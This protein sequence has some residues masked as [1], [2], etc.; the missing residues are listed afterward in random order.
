M[1]ILR[2]RQRSVGLAQHE[3]W[4]LFSASA[5]ILKSILETDT[6]VDLICGPARAG[7]KQVFEI[8][9]EE[10]S[11]ALLHDH[12]TRV[13]QTPDA[14]RALTLA[15]QTARCGK[16]AI[17]LIPN[18]QL[19]T[20]LPFMPDNA[21][22]AFASGQSLCVLLEDDP[23]VADASCPRVVVSRLKI[24]T[25]EPANVQQL[26]DAIDH[27]LRV[28]RAESGPVCV[29]V[30]QSILRSTYTLQAKPNRVMDSVDAILASPRRP[31]R[32]RIAE[33]GGA[34][35]VARRLQLNQSRNMPNPGE[36]VPIGFITIGPTEEALA[37]LIHV[38]GLHGRIPVLQLG[39]IQPL[40]ASSIQRILSRCEQ[41]A[42]LEPRSGSI[43]AGVLRIAE[44]MRIDGHRPAAVIGGSLN[45]ASNQ[46]TSNSVVDSSIHPSSLARKIV[47]LLH[48]VRPSLQLANELVKD[49]PVPTPGPPPRR[50]ESGSAEAISVIRRTLVDIDQWLRDRAASESDQIGP[51]AMTINGVGIDSPSEN[52]VRAEVWAYQQFLT[53]GLAAIK[54]ITDEPSQALLVV[55]AVGC[56]EPQDLLRAISGVIPSQHAAN[57]RVKTVDINDRVAFRDLLKEELLSAMTSI[58]V[59]K[60]G[61]PARFDIVK[62]EQSLSEIDRLGYEP[63]QRSIRSAQDA[64]AGRILPQAEQLHE[65]DQ[66]SLQSFKSELTV[67]RLSKRSA[68]HWRA[69]IVPISEQIEVIRSQPPL[70]AGR[71]SSQGRLS[72]PNPIHAK[73]LNWRVHL[74][75]FRGQPPGLAALALSEAAR[76]MGYHVRSIY[77][78]TPIGPG[79]R[80]WCQ[81][82]LGRALHDKSLGPISTVIPYSEADLLL[83]YD[84]Q[85][86]L[87]A[88][89]GDGD[90]RVASPDKTCTVLN[91]GMFSD[92]QLSATIPNDNDDLLAAIELVTKVDHL[93]QN[94]YAAAC[95]RVF[96]TDRVTDLALLGTA[97][98]CGFIP[99]SLEAIE[100]GLR[101]IERRGFGRSLEAFHFGRQ[102]ASDAKLF[103][104]P[105]PQVEEALNRLIRRLIHSVRAQPWGGRKR[106]AL[107]EALVNR[108]LS[109][110]P[111]LAESDAGRKARR[112]L[113]VAMGRC[114]AWGGIDYA[115]QYA[116]FIT[117]IYEVDRGDTA[118]ALTRNAIRPLAEA[119][120]IRDPLYVSTII[121]TGVQRQVMKQAL[122]VKLARGDQVRRRYLTRFE[123]LA[124]NRRYRFDICTS[125]WLIHALALSRHIVPRYWRGSTLERS[126]RSYVIEIVQ[127]TVIN[128]QDNYEVAANVLARLNAQTL[129]DRLRSMALTEL[130]MF[131]EGGAMPQATQE[132]QSQQISAPAMS[133]LRSLS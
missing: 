125:D 76:S 26:H 40:D 67:S 47:H 119:M 69:R 17:A 112:E 97:Y 71:A 16:R 84:S 123:L 77:D 116:Q 127:K 101:Y 100:T 118:R 62:I 60:D 14:I 31:D 36:R 63:L 11:R 96:L 93:H 6:V 89:T 39:L 111:G 75:G 99:V 2:S 34:L 66:Q 8:A 133:D 53:Q 98:Q 88:V 126:I 20:A 68:V 115:R 29:V 92:E 74:A 114:L 19:S 52:V 113:V 22:E 129:D 41:V 95:R 70:R 106:A 25:L 120:L 57:V 24:P 56:S 61:P 87:R 72:L 103:T 130:S 64:C 55:S 91:A 32:P 45:L 58:I 102:L 35:R 128:A 48:T 80:A 83:G 18:S 85:E 42:V 43:E 46:Q 94:D 51:V 15:V 107:F 109:E 44:V 4:G 121:T 1:S 108:I 79:R 49:L 28:S 7:F 81:L 65:V 10:K 3:G 90:L 30:H 110:M 117:S 54:Q 78:P 38:L 5:A 23:A 33:V 59:A 27:A 104:R 21:D 13:L 86:T 50:S 124:F 82:L 131:V 73:Q 122:N 37:H 12:G 9:A 105:T 132:I